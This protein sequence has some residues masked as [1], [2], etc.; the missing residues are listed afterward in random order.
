[1]MIND[2]LLVVGRWER[3]EECALGRVQKWSHETASGTGRDSISLEGALRSK[4]TSK[5]EL[6]D[7]MAK[8]RR[9]EKH[10]RRSS[11]RGA[12]PA[13][14]ELRASAAAAISKREAEF[15]RAF[16]QAAIGMAL[17]ALDGGWLRV[18]PVLCQIVGYSESELLATDFQS[19]TH[20]E[21]LS[22]DLAFVGQ[23]LRGEIRSYQMEKR[24]L[25]RAQ[26]IVWVL[27]S[28]SLVYGRGGKPLFFFAQIQD[29][30]ESKRMEAALRE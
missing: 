25:H 20:P 19:I 21:D 18:N 26:H 15:R 3:V 2:P 16:D 28:V 13:S 30:S 10:G 27:L 23:M 9:P 6:D 11:R 24:Y 5:T 1:M 8:D 4:R 29:I 14:S 22:A 12:S 7:R 17:V